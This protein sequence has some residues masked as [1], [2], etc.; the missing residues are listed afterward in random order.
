MITE[1]LIVCRIIQSDDS[2]CAYIIKYNSLK[3]ENPVAHLAILIGG[4]IFIVATCM[5]RIERMVSDHS[6]AYLRY[7]SIV[8]L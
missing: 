1:W 2:D 3:F 4:E 7:F 6:E 5:P 8:V